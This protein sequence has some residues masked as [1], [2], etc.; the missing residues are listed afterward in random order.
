MNKEPTKSGFEV[1]CI[2]ARRMYCFTQKAGVCRKAK[3]QMNRRNRHEWKQ[4]KRNGKE[5]RNATDI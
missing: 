4:E 1:D 5:E 2:C 3:R